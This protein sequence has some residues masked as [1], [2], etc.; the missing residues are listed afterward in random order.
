MSDDVRP[1]LM[2]RE[3]CSS[4]EARSEFHTLVE[5]SDWDQGFIFFSPPP[6]LI[7]FG[8]PL[9]VV[10]SGGGWVLHGVVARKVG[11]LG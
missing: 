11:C 6:L 5:K 7:F 2:M 9:I 10:H 1:E 4:S 8:P 3:C